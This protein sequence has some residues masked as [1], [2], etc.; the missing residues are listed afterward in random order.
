MVMAFDNSE[1]QTMEMYL[2][3]KLS[4]DTIYYG[5]NDLAFICNM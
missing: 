3:Q 4:S 5:W 1:D 2:N